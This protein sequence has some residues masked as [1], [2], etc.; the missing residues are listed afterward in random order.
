M[1]VLILQGIVSFFFVMSLILWC[2]VAMVG[3]VS[4]EQP[5]ERSFI[6]F[7]TAKTAVEIYFLTC[8]TWNETG[9]LCSAIG[10]L[11]CVVCI[12]MGNR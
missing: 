12:L 6:S 4:V 11:V 5:L 3:I 7:L 2:V 8:F 10:A 1:A 9:I